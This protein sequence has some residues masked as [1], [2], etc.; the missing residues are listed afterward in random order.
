MKAK[1]LCIDPAVEQLVVVSDLHAFV[2]PLDEIDKWRA[3]LSVPSQVIVNGDL[4]SMGIESLRTLKW[5]RD[6]A[7]EYVV[8]GNHDEEVLQRTEG[9]FPLYDTA[10]VSQ[11]LTQEQ[12]EYVGQLP[13]K[14]EV[15]W[16][17]RLLRLMH[18]HRTLS[19]EMRPPDS[20][21]T[22][23]SQLARLYGDPA[24]DLTI[25]GH[26]H[27]AFVRRQGDVFLANCG[28]ASLPIRTVEQEDG[29][30]V[31]QG[32]GPPVE[33]GG[34]LRSTFLSMRER[35]GVLDVEIVRFD[36]DRAAAV[37]QLERAGYPH[38]RRLRLLF[39]EGLLVRDE[40]GSDVVQGGHVH[41]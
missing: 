4:F 29:T 26:T 18:G 31:S 11:L 16:R 7:G 36:Y 41:R 5:V 13:F 3:G 37:Q 15:R 39:A 33:T 35:E 34:D 1:S 17:G 32:D 23:P 14:L 27:H 10:G 21:M 28:S 25:L 2:A 19:G 6:C 8:M 38:M 9:D 24:V 20:F 12:K 30:V 22:T 40:R